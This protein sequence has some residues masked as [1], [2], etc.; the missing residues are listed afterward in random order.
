MGSRSRYDEEA[1]GRACIK[2]GILAVTTLSGANA[3]LRAIRYTTLIT[4]V[5]SLQEYHS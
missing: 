2:Y 4:K 5:R 3:V 1:I